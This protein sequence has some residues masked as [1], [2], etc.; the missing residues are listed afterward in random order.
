M[1]KILTDLRDAFFP[2]QPGQVPDCIILDHPKA[3]NPYLSRYG[4][5]RWEEEIKNVDRMKKYVCNTDVIE[6]IM[7]ESNRVMQGTKHAND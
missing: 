7:H 1:K 2:S 3:E 4:A 5:D 6:H